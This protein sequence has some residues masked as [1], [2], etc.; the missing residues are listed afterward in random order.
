MRYGGA[1][2]IKTFIGP[3]ITLLLVVAGAAALSIK[4]DAIFAMGYDKCYA[5][6]G[7]ATD[8]SVQQLEDQLQGGAAPTGAGA[9]T[10][11]MQSGSN[12]APVAQ[13]AV[14]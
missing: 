7:P 11:G 6:Y 12:G 8:I 4:Y 3:F 10:K 2:D 1:M 14:Q 5:E 13:P 9:S